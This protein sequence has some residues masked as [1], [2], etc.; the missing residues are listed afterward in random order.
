M[1]ITEQADKT[2]Q[3]VLDPDGD[4]E[5]SIEN[6]VDERDHHILLLKG[7]EH[8]PHDFYRIKRMCHR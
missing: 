1:T 7:A 3:A 4:R 6:V 2:L 8:G 5:A